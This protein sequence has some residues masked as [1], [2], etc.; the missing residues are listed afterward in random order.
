MA[1]FEMKHVNQYFIGF[2]AEITKYQWPDPFES[3]DDARSVLQGFLNEMDREETLIYSILSKDDA[4]LGS[5][6]VH[7]LTGECPELGVWITAPEQKKG[8]AYEALSAVLE[9]VRSSYGKTAFYYEADIRNAGSMKLL[10]KFSDEYEIIEQGFER[11]TT[12]SGKDLELQG[13]ILKA[14]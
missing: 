6:E 8:Y 9:H 14:K 4:F 5:V 2:N 3:M 13:Y 10:R 11:L 7:G 12:D 1:P